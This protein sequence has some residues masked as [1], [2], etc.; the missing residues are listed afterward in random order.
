VL[1]HGRRCPIV[2][3]SANAT[4]VRLGDADAKAGDQA[5]FIGTQGKERILLSEVATL[6]GASVYSVAM[7][8]SPLLS[9]FLV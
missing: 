3:I 2:A 7:G 4:I 8:M 1:I 9:R 6:T 5:V